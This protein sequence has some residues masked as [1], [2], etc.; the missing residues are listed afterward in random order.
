MNATLHNGK[1]EE[2]VEG[3]FC[4]NMT[5]Q[6]ECS[7]PR[8]CYSGVQGV[9]GHGYSF[10]PLSV[11]RISETNAASITLSVL[12]SR[13]KRVY[14]GQIFGIRVRVSRFPLS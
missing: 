14:V 9:G 10:V 1:S 11:M 7:L 8:F 13:R 5:G 2:V 4:P 3:R 6:L 12:K